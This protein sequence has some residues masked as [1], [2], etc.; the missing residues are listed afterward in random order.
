[1]DSAS[2]MAEKKTPRK[3][4]PRRSRIDARDLKHFRHLCTML[5][6]RVEIAAMATTAF[7]HH[8]ALESVRELI[9][10]IEIGHDTALCILEKELTGNC[11]LCGAKLPE[12]GGCPSCTVPQ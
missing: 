10:E 3:K 7:E 12:V 8:Q 1:M 9:E 11:D 2:L 6:L 5:G 4:K